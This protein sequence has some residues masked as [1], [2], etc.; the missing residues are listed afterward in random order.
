MH[1]L[2]K[3]FFQKRSLSE[4]IE[5]NESLYNAILFLEKSN[6]IT[7][8]LCNK[9]VSKL[10]GNV[11]WPSMHDMYKRNYEYCCGALGCFIIAQFPSSEA[12]C[13]TAIEGAVNLHYMSIGDSMGKQI[14]YFKSY[15]ETERK[16]NRNWK[17]SIESS[18]YPSNA[19]QHH[20]ERIN[21]KEKV[22]NEYDVM[23]RKSLA[24]A[25]VDY[26]SS[27]Q[28]W[29]SIFDR[30]KEVGDEVGYRTVYVALCSQA[31]NDAED[32]LNSIVTRVV[33]NAEGLEEATFLE[34]YMFS[35]YMLLTALQYNVMATVMYVAKFNI[36]AEE[37]ISIWKDIVQEIS[38]IT[39]IG[40]EVISNKI[41][42]K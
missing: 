27:N 36:K 31:H 25:G 9:N 18:S 24:L 30:F 37:L 13:R 11:A 15:L 26:D 38:N 21:N 29:P 7:N 6:E 19:K 10:E 28:R 22:L 4:E 35:L 34:Q 41:K 2:V 39:E 33:E 42:M 20:F 14:S 17:A 12:L 23:L 1:Q 3:K 16:Q 8:R 5:L 32:I 40:P